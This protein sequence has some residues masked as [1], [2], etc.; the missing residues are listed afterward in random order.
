MIAR[1]LTTL[2]PPPPGFAPVALSKRKLLSTTV[3]LLLRDPGEIEVILPDARSRMRG[4][5]LTLADSGMCLRLGPSLWHLQL[6]AA[7]LP[8]IPALL[9]GFATAAADGHEAA[10][11]AQSRAIGLARLRQDLV[12]T[13]RD[14][15]ESLNHLTESEERFRA[16]VETSWDWI[17][18]TDANGHFTYSSPRARDLLG[19]EPEEILGRGFT[20]LM[21]PEQAARIW[22]LFE[23]AAVAKRPLLN[24]ENAIRHRDGR[25]VVL[26]T[27]AAPILDT[28]GAWL[29]F[30]GIGRDITER[31]RVEEER[32][33][34]ERQ[35]LHTQKLESLGVLAAGIANDFNNLLVTVLGNAELALLDMP[36]AAAG[37]EAVI[38]IRRAALRAS[39]LTSQML[40]YSGR[41]HFEV[42]AVDLSALVSEVG[43]LLQISVCKRAR[44]NF[45]LATDLPPIQ[46]DA[47]HMRQV[48]INLVTNA[49][50]ALDSTQTEGAITLRTDLV[51]ASRDRLRASAL[52]GDLPAGDYAALE[53]CDNGCGMT[54]DV[55]ARIFD[56]FFT[57][58]FQGRGLG[59]AA[60]QGIVRG[61]RG[62]LE[63]RSQIGQGTSVTML[64]PITPRTAVAPTPPMPSQ[65]SDSCGSGMIL[66]IDDDQ[67]VREFTRRVLERQGYSVLT[68]GGGEEGVEI[69]RAHLQTIAVVL[70]DL[71]MPAMDGVQT[72]EELKR[73]RGDIPVILASGHSEREATSHFAGL[74]LTGFL[75]KPFTIS[76]LAATVRSAIAG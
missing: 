15:N 27:S 48:I 25:L 26:E 40:A 14:Y 68:A 57:T 21:P 17:W 71:T 62:T 39:D 49:A 28:R 58:K 7:V 72:F 67:N 12:L 64:L 56:P 10:E 32:L 70:L 24:I 13:R 5:L 46:A 35:I 50:E 54:E 3:V 41:G 52:G 9:T 20:D 38:D 11:L 74:G 16:L 19:Y 6:P 18:A 34:F 75:K 69:Y 36:A 43:R 33:R 73:L 30:R 44:L 55:Q 60:V 53:V 66:V 45:E 37:R 63:I 2:S 65:P 4:L 76:E 42:A 51:E 22:P 59:M 31:K 47:A 61:H 1:L 8:A 23:A 29:G